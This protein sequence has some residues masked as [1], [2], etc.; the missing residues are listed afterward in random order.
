MERFQGL[1]GIAVIFGVAILFSR[2]RSRINWR[3]L[4]VGLAL[5]VAFALLVIKW[6]PGFKALEWVALRITDAISFTDR[7]TEFVFGGLLPKDNGFVFALNVLPVIIFLGAIIGALYYL[8]VI[9]V[10]VDLLGTA[11]QKLLGTSAHIRLAI[12]L[13]HAAPDDALREKKRKS[14]DRIATFLG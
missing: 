14:T 6:E 1:L 9:Q 2:H 12:A 8:R 11:L 5:Q 7:G 13:G 10:F 4:G 3:T